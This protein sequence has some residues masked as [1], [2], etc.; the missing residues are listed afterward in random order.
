MHGELNSKSTNILFSPRIPENLISS[1]EAEYQKKN[2]MTL[3]QED[4]APYLFIS[5]SISHRDDG[6]PE[7][8]A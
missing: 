1:E 2:I 7:N 6:I 5:E 8:S 4:K 3:K